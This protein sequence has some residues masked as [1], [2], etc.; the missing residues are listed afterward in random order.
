MAL[1]LEIQNLAVSNPGIGRSIT[2][3]TPGLRMTVGC[4]CRL[5]SDP[6]IE[7]QAGKRTLP[8]GPYAAYREAEATGEIQVALILL[9]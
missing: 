9:P 8:G 5:V 3:R 6:G 7:P 2:S 4:L 1:A